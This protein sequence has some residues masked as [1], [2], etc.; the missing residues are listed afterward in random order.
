MQP[1]TATTQPMNINTHLNV[2][3]A[4]RFCFMCRH[5][6]TTAN[7]SFREADTPRGTALLLDRVRMEPAMLSN[8]D[9]IRALY[10]NTLSASCRQHCVSHYDEAGL[11]LAARRDIVEQ[12]H[13]PADVRALAEDLTAAF[14]AKLTGVIRGSDKRQSGSGVPPLF[15]KRQDAASTMQ[16]ADIAP[17]LSGKG[18]NLLHLRVTDKNNDDTPVAAALATIAEKVGAKFAT[19]QTTDTGKAH[20][21]LGYARQAADIARQVAALITESACETLVTSCPAAYDALKNDYP[22]W[23]I[24]LPKTLRI[25]H[26]TEWLAELLEQKK[27]AAATKAPAAPACACISSDYLRNYNNAELPLVLLRSLGY[28]PKPFGTN[29]EESFALGEGAVIFAR[30]RPDLTKLLVQRLAQHMDSPDDTIIT[31]SPYTRR[32]LAEA[33][34]PV[35]SL[36]EAVAARI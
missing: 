5:L 4:C 8:A 28:A 31:S 12:N 16:S 23:G 18:G 9:Y 29:S 7:V 22:A 11:V 19:L 20:S 32:I 25:L 10:D 21:V 26:T 36:E 17:K 35:L 15:D 27:L 3:N 24:Q 30:L 34:I 6:A 2:I 33:K 1:A 13:A 14:T